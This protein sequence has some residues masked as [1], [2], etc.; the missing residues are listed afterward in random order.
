MELTEKEQQARKRVC[1]ALD[2]PTV[3]EALSLAGE[4]SDYVGMCKIGKELH[5]VAGNE[6]VPIVREI[7]DRKGAAF[8]D[9]K[10]HDTPNTFYG[11]AKASA[12]PGVSFFNIHVAGGE[13][14]CKKAVEGA[15]EGA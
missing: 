11:A 5:T 8:L 9:L 2:V 6:G 15:Y 3:D 4:L 1:L 7:F 10:Y 14:M 12:V 13:E